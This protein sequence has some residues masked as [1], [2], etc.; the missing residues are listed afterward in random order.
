ME[1]GF[2][3]FLGLIVLLQQGFYSWQIHKLLDKSMSKSFP[4]YVQTKALDKQNKN[5][6]TVIKIPLDDSVSEDAEYIRDAN[7]QLLGR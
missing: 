3:L 4:E 5:H 2:I 7:R 1:H 6:A